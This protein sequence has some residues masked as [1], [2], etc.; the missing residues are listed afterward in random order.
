VDTCTANCALDGIDAKTWSSTYGVAA[1]SNG[2]VNMS[3]VTNGTYSRNV[4]SRTYLAASDDK[5][6][7]FKLLNKEFTFDV[8]AGM[9]PCGLNGAVYF[10]EMEE[11]GGLAK[12]GKNKAGAKFGTGYCDAQCPHDLKWIN[13]EANIIGWNSSKTDPNAGV[14]KYGTCCAELDIWEANKISTQMTVHDCSTEGQHRCEGIECGDN[15]KG[16][17]FKGV[18]DKDGCDFNP[19]RVGAKNFYGPGPDFTINSLKPVTVVTQFITSDGT[20]TGDLVEMRR[21]Y[22]QDGKVVNNPSASYGKYD[23]VSDEMC[24]A[25]KKN[26]TD[27]D[28]FIPKG[29]MKGMGEAMKR[30]LVLTI[31]LWDDHDVGMIWLDATDPYPVPSGKYGA[32]RGTCSQASGNPKLVENSYPHAYVVYSNIKYG[33]IGSTYGNTQPLEPSPPSPSNCPGGSLS[34]CID[35]C[36]SSI[37]GACIQS[38]SKRCGATT[39]KR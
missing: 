23:S 12:Y 10:V 19:Y 17:R 28:D 20:D 2:L 34:A 1:N 37:F 8:D 9:L 33:E 25:Q 13:G 35:M 4:G 6:K 22:V 7:M 21:L 16:E 30:G 15:A 5:Y 36:P 38:C 18:C 14:G 32:P 26:F 39:T 24:T 31:S 27:V 11:D 29:G 3:F